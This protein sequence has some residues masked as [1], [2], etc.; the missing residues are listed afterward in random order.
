MRVLYMEDDPIQLEIVQ[1]WLVVNGHSVLGVADA[2]AATAAMMRDTFDLV[3]LDWMVPRGSGQDVLNW[4]R[5]REITVPILFATSCE[6]EFEIAGILQLGA[7]DYLVKPLRR[8]EFVARV[9]ALGRRAGVFGMGIRGG[10]TL[11][12]YTIDA[13]RES[14]SISGKPV[15]MTRRLTKL[16]IYLFR[17]CNMDVSRAQLYEEVWQHKEEL[18]TRTLDT[19]ICRLRQLLELDGR[20]GV[21]LASVYQT[22][23]RLETCV[24]EMAVAA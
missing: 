13:R 18:Y 3:V 17:R 19:H 24:P 8:V 5:S 23:Y 16:A 2:D 10:W 9:E 14:V 1:K 21:R 22:G 6:G 7:D 20:H 12:P 4:I 11:G 15:R